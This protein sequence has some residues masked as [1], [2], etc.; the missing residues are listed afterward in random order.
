MLE[1]FEDAF[2]FASDCLEQIL[3]VGRLI[4]RFLIFISLPFWIIP[5]AIYKA[6]KERENNGI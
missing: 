1:D 6:K 2:Y 5:Y 3:Y 4:L